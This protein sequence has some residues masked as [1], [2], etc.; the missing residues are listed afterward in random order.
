MIMNAPQ[1]SL[2]SS[3]NQDSK[4]N[5]VFMLPGYAWIILVTLILYAICVPFSILTYGVNDPFGDNGTFIEKYAYL[6]TTLHDGLDLEWRRIMGFG[7][8]ALTQRMVLLFLSPILT[9]EPHSL[10][11]I[12]F[13]VFMMAAMVIF[14]MAISAGCTKAVGLICS[15][16]PWVYPTMFG[17]AP[18]GPAG[19][20]AFTS[21]NID[22]V[23][24]SAIVAFGAATALFATQPWGRW[25]LVL[26]VIVM[27]AAMLSRQSAI[28]TA[29]LI[30]LP[31][32]LAAAY[33][34]SR[35]HDAQ[36]TFRGLVHVSAAIIFAGVVIFLRVDIMKSYYG[37]SFKS[38]ALG[39]FSWESMAESISDYQFVLDWLMLG[40]IT[41]KFDLAIAANLIVLSSLYAVWRYIRNRDSNAENAIAAVMALSAASLFY[42]TYS[43]GIL[44]GVRVWFHSY[45]GFLPMLA[46][47]SLSLIAIILMVLRAWRPRMGI[48]MAACAAISTA[49]LSNA[50]WM[51]KTTANTIQV[52]ANPANVAR[53]AS[54][55]DFDQFDKKIAWLWYSHYNRSVINYH[56]VQAGLASVSEMPMPENVRYAIWMGGRGD[57]NGLLERYGS[58]LD[59]LFKHAE[60]LFIPEH[61]ILFH[62]HPGPYPFRLYP[63][64]LIKKLNAPDGPRLLV[65]ERL[66]SAQKGVPYNM[67][68]VQ[69]VRDG[70]KPCSGEPLPLPYGSVISTENVSLKVPPLKTIELLENNT[71]S[72]RIRLRDNADNLRNYELPKNFFPPEIYDPVLLDTF[73]EVE[74]IVK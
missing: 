26:L 7:D 31:G 53:F 29:L 28:A 41:W 49:F 50:Y 5:K 55:L 59:Y 56:R 42:G 70:M 15:L 4:P 57:I 71:G 8:P 36:Q 66:L 11:L 14:Y 33:A 54:S 21:L 72:Y 23:F 19:Y 20:F 10:M 35:S 69:V 65:C 3:N 63:E 17:S 2:P 64:V 30:L 12:N 44:S 58:S 34:I 9:T 1:V 38:E 46:G 16:I 61:P 68:L 52:G 24:Y 43:A 47:L 40:K 32:L 6:V 25:R 74:E 27:A 45:Q 48:S 39:S 37:N 73:P 60:Y 18:V 22:V 51:E 67:L 13:V 62:V